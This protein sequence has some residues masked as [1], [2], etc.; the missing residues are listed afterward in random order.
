MISRRSLIA[1]A[2]TLVAP[3]MG[4]LYL[5]LPLRALA[6]ATGGLALAVLAY[7]AILT[8]A[9]SPRLAWLLLLAP[10]AWLVFV[11]WDAARRARTAVDSDAWYQRWYIFALI[12]VA[13]GMAIGPFTGVGKSRIVRAFRLPSGS[14]EPTLMVGDYV[15]ADM[16]SSARAGASRGSIVMFMSVEEPGLQV[17][18]RI[19]AL[20]G[21]TVA[22]RAGKLILNG[23]PVDEPYLASPAALHGSEADQRAAMLKWQEP[24]LAQRDS[25]SLH[26]DLNDWGPVVMPHETFLVLG[27]NRQASYDGR[28]WG[29]LPQ[30]NLL[31]RPVMIY[32][33]F[34]PVG[35]KPFPYF[36]AMRRSRFGMRPT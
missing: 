7:G 30:R 29:P 26:P 35:W 24:L 22:M 17:M 23:K 3:G 27:D 12:A 8:P 28:F 15:Y 14:M 19:V 18:K 16:R 31:G 33:S 5:G 20:G 21:D 25:V 13:V 32:Y 10:S 9:F 2:L 6:M 1:A 34:D 4:Q 11:A 36:T